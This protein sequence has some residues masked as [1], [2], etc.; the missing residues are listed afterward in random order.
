MFLLGANTLAYLALSLAIKKKSFI[1][2]TPGG[3]TTLDI[4][5]FSITL[6]IKCSFVALSINGT[7][8]IRPQHTNLLLMQNVHFNYCYAECRYAECQLLNVVMLSVLAPSCGLLYTTIFRVI[9]LFTVVIN[10]QM[11]II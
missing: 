9:K 6:S 1:T 2:L 4:A 3:T 10:L 8:H 5:T 11:F 7:H